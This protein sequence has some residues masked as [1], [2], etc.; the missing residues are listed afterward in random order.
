[1]ASRPLYNPDPDTFVAKDLV[2]MQDMQ[3]VRLSDFVV[4]ALQINIQE[5]KVRLAEVDLFENVYIRGAKP[6]L[7]CVTEGHPACAPD[8]TIMSHEDRAYP[9]STG[10]PAGPWTTKTVKDCP[11]Y[12]EWLKRIIQSAQDLYARGVDIQRKNMLLPDPA[13]LAVANALVLMPMKR[14]AKAEDSDGGEG[15]GNEGGGKHKRSKK[16]S[17]AERSGGE[18]KGRTTGF[19]NGSPDETP[20]E[21][22]ERL[23]SEVGNVLESFTSDVM[24]R[25][26]FVDKKERAEL[27]FL[28][29][30][31]LRNG[32]KAAAD[33][34]TDALPGGLRSLHCPDGGNS[35]GTG[36]SGNDGG[37]AAQ[38]GEASGCDGGGASGGACQSSKDGGK[39]GGGGSVKAT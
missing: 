37:D 7:S 29:R 10:K 8:N 12:D 15:D 11:G 6:C 16:G 9:G 1:M 25:K 2:S 21:K 4:I 23:I 24:S 36:Q 33:W 13:D 20:R 26:N 30:R 35:G 17:M 18:G 3:R 28:M 5:G 31:Q 34:A 27:I 22:A 39:S 38:S 32:I 14:K 19:S